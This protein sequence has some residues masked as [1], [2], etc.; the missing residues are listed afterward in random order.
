MAEL[1]SKALKMKGKMTRDGMTFY[2]KKGKTILRSS[3]SEQPHR[4]TH[5]QFVS[6]Q[7]VTSNMRYENASRGPANPSFS[8]GQA[9][10]PAFAR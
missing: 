7:R 4:R 3:I 10:T 5:G 6:R 8:A 2:Q 1:I 9:I